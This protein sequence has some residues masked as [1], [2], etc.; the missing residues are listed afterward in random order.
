MQV[1]IKIRTSVLSGWKFRIN[2]TVLFP[3]PGPTPSLNV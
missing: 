2:N 3:G 1:A